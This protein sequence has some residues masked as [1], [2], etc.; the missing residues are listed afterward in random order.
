MPLKLTGIDE[1]QYPPHQFFFIAHFDDLLWP[2]A[3]FDIHVQDRIK[4]MVLRQ[5]IAVFLS[6]P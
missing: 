3:L 6:R 1:F 4:D 5:A 2:E